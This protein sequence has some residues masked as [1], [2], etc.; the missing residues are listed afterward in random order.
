LPKLLETKFL[1]LHITG[2]KK[3]TVLENA[4]NGSDKLELPIR[5]VLFQNQTPLDIYYAA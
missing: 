3:F 4:I 2:E 5:S 1:A